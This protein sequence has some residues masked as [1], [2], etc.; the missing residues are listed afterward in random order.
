[1]RGKAVSRVWE[2]LAL[3]EAWTTLRQ[4]GRCVFC[5][6]CQAAEKTVELLSSS[7][8]HLSRRAVRPER[9]K[10]FRVYGKWV[11]VPSEPEK[12]QAAEA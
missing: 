6:T 1:M 3:V 10:L 8:M 4:D 7:G 9:T 5:L 11:A 12:L 2:Q